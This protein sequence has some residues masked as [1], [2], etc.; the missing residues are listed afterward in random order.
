MT[1]TLPV[2]RMPATSRTQPVHATLRIPFGSR[3]LF[4]VKVPIVPGG[5]LCG[6][7]GTYSVTLSEEAIT[8]RLT[9]ET[10]TRL[11][12]ADQVIPDGIYTVLGPGGLLTMPDG[13]QGGVVLLGPQGDPSQ[14]WDVTF[15]SGSYTLRNVQTGSYLGNDGDPSQPAMQVRGTIQPYA[16]DLSQGPDDR[17]ETFIL[18]SSGPS[19]GLLLGLS[20]LR[21]YPPQLAILRPGQFGPTVEWEFT[22]AGS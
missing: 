8:E 21:I 20:L 17:A 10:E 14:Q 12:M 18:T 19:D 2:T 22:P 15:R 9:S 13:P 4:R 3:C 7:S 16:W 5:G 11:I 6:S 1:R